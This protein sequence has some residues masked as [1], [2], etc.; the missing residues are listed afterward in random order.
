VSAVPGLDGDPA[1]CSQAGGSLRRLATSLR[2]AHRTA[3][4]AGSE[5]AEAWSGR[6]SVAARR[7]HEAVTSSAATAV[8]EL[9]A[10]G[11]QLQEHATDLAEAL[12]T[13]RSVT[14]RAE[15]AGLQVHDGRVL[16]AWGVTGV[17]DPELAR[18]REETAARLQAELDT[19]TLQLSRRRARLAAAAASGRERLARAAEG[20]RR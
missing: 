16:A 19:A 17:A 6:A 20:L 12:Q 7:Q 2:T 14:D 1:S 8:E 3:A 11:S 4:G 9:D 15:A 18:A 5:L 13:A 10:M